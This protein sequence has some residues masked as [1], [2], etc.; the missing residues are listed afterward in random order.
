MSNRK[1]FRAIGQID[2]DLIEEAAEYKVSRKKQK[3]WVSVGAMAAC[4]VIAVSA[5]SV[6][7]K[8]TA[9]SV[10]TAAESA[11]ETAATTADTTAAYDSQIASRAVVAGELEV[12]ATDESDG[13]IAVDTGFVISGSGLTIQELSERIVISP[14]T[15][16][17][18]EEL[19]DDEFLITPTASL[20]SNSL[21]NIELDDENGTTV[22]KWAFQT[23]D[24]FRVTSTYPMGDYAS[25]NTGIEIAFN[26]EI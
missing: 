5:G 25:S 4:A 13:Y 17:V 20:V 3:I 7:G 6:L 10:V 18:L 21:V 9:Q 26:T 11:A 12:V 8:K 15:D 23:E 2:E 19:N 16:F 22:G 14:D 1:L 24:V